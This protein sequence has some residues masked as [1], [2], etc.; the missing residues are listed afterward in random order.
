ML[1]YFGFVFLL[2]V[3]VVLNFASFADSRENKKIHLSSKNTIAIRD[4]IDD[5]TVTEIRTAI[6]GMR[7]LRSKQP[8]YLVLYTPG[9]SVSAGLEIVEIL[10]GLG[11]PVHTI[12]LV[13]ASMGFQI[14]Q[15]LDDRY[16]TESGT[17][18]SHR[19]SGG[20]EGQFGGVEPSQLTSRYLFHVQ[21]IREL[22]EQTV[23]RTKGKQTLASY[24]AAY[25]NE[26]WLSGSKAIE[27][28]YADEVV[29]VSCDKD[30]DGTEERH[31]TFMGFPV[32]Y[33][34]DSCPLSSALIRAEIET[35]GEVAEAVKALVLENFRV[36]R[37]KR[38]NIHR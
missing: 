29:T 32:K 27:Q 19:A 24:T 1:K 8:I 2:A 3:A 20:F 25:A 11:R 31:I 9:G 12:T 28:G 30:L 23:K 38:L 13:A 21:R 14:V 5:S 26:L 6:K 4:A 22:D 33:E 16:I 36:D 34:I 35:K 15:H 37:D 18:M 7:D 17:L 10:K